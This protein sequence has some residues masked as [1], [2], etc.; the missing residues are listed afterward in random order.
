MGQKRPLVFLGVAVVLALV[1]TVMVYQWLQGQRGL[2][3][4]TAEVVAEEG[5]NVAVALVD[6]AWGT[7]LAAQTIR[8]VT[9][10]EGGLACG[11]LYESRYVEWASRASKSQ[12]K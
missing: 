3:V 4:E 5:I 7:P 12:K 1:T 10:P 8:M 2:E 11:A 6:I 9:Y